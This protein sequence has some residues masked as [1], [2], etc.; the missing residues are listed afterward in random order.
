A[1]LRGTAP[2]ARRDSRWAT[3]PRGSI[4]QRQQL[5]F[6]TRRDPGQL[7]P[8]RQRA[9]GS[10]RRTSPS[11]RGF[12]GTSDPPRCVTRPQPDLVRAG[13]VRS[14]RTTGRHLRLGGPRV[15]DA[16]RPLGRVARAGRERAAHSKEH[17]GGQRFQLQRDPGSSFGR[18]GSRRTDY[19]RINVV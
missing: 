16:T 19:L 18:T 10:H 4:E 12:G 6:L 1:L 17:I 8:N 5:R 9:R 14:A 15:G 13:T 11:P 3:R 7:R 2:A